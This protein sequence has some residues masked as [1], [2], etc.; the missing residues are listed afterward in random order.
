MDPSTAIGT[1]LAIL[2]SKEIVV[3]ILGPTAEYL[4]GELQSYTKKGATNLRRIFSHA[5]TK[6]GDKLNDQGQVAPKV[7]KGILSEGYFCDDELGAEYFGGV[8]AGSRSE[9]PRD[10]R[11][12]AILSLISRLS[13]YQ[14]RSHYLFYTA[15]KFL[16]DRE[17]ANLGISRERANLKVFF[18]L[19]AYH[20]A[21]GFSRSEDFSALLSH[22]M[23][24]LAREQLIGDHWGSGTPQYLQKE[25]H[26]SNNEAGIVY[27]ASAI[28][29]ELYL[30]AH[31][32][33]DAI[34]DFLKAS[35]KFEPLAE[36]SLLANA[37]ERVTG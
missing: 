36:I 23:N 32:R 9:V 6:L 33:R 37:A 7:L 3:K 31:G 14:L 8:L 16:Y 25:F 21:M 35:V 4:G 27:S 34:G 29:L 10:D 2:G 22:A 5:E 18:R 15:F 28:G 26:T 13:T 19:S 12:A 20:E 11:G 24:G 17:P 1:G 30:W